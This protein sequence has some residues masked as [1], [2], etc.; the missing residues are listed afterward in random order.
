MVEEAISFWT[1]IQRF[2]DMLVADPRS[3]SF[4]PLS[5]LYRKLGLLDDAVSVAKKGC[6]LH[7]E[8]AG[9]FFALGSAYFDKGLKNESR[10][11][12]ERVVRLSP[13]NLRAQ[14]LL[15]QLYVEAGETGLAQRALEQVL[16]Q[17]PEDSESALLLQSLPATT[18]VEAEELDDEFLEDLEIIEDLEELEELSEVPAAA[19]SAS[20]PRQAPLVAELPEA[21][22]MLDFPDFHEIAEPPELPV[23][24]ETLQFPEFPEAAEISQVI[25]VTTALQGPEELAEFD[26]LE[27]FVELAAP[28]QYP[29]RDPL[30]TPTLAEL[31]VSQGFIGQAVAIYQELIAADPG[32]QPYRLRCAEL[33][34]AGE[35]QLGAAAIPVPP[36]VP[37]TAAP[38]EETAAVHLG[39]EAELSR[40]L[41]NIRR[42][43]DGV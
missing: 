16:Q 1:E 11:A 8:Y 32:N 18:Q 14:K 20:S 42:R 27:E 37:R 29:A 4:A 36:F 7:P 30:T 31:Y 17:N 12:L 13:E 3:L 9:G 10:T 38:Q 40:W 26:E 43:K 22:D 25:E 5:E 35:R 33:K 24:P 15:G 23:A 41:E 19:G 34:A 21:P 6:E 39:P 2:E 28:A